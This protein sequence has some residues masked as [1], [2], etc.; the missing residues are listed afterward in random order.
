MNE[1]LYVTDEELAM[2]TSIMQ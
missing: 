1:S 2:C